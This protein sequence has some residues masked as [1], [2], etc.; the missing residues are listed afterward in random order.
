MPKT[1]GEGEA[2]ETVD[3][4]RR[5]MIS[6]DPT[7]EDAEERDRNYWRVLVNVVYAMELVSW[8]F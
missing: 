1:G 8:R 5:S 3:G 6:E 7:E 2:Y 4:V